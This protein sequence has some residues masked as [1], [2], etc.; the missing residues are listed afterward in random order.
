MYLGSDMD[1]LLPVVEQLVAVETRLWNRLDR[2]LGEQGCVPLPQLVA[3]R[4]LHRRPGSRVR[5]LAAELDISPGGAS[6]LVD[7]LV[8]AGTVERTADAEDRRAAVLRLTD[9]GHEAVRLA[10]E[11]SEAWLVERFA[12]ELSELCP[13]LTRMGARLGEGVSVA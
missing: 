8:A 5:D 9:K 7:R 3:L 10:S 6:K 13:A 4:V 2:V 11:V 12:G 1:D